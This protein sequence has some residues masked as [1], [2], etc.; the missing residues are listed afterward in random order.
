MRHSRDERSSSAIVAGR[1]EV[2]EILVG[3]VLSYLIARDQRKFPQRRSKSYSGMLRARPFL[4]TRV[5]WRLIWQ[6]RK[7]M[8]RSDAAVARVPVRRRRLTYAVR[9]S[10][11]PRAP[12]A[13]ILVGAGTP[14]ASRSRSNPSRNSRVERGHDCPLSLGANAGRVFEKAARASDPDARRLDVRTTAPASDPR[15]L[16]RA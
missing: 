7:R 6:A 14:P 12:T 3:A 4:E 13:R 16:R 15:P 8:R 10:V 1:A 5:S 11:R 2:V 9:S